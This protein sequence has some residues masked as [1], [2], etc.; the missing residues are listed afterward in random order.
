ML[1]EYVIVSI[2][3]FTLL[4]LLPKITNPS[5][6]VG[7]YIVGALLCGFSSLVLLYAGL[8]V[9]QLF[10]LPQ[11]LAL[12]AIHAVVPIFSV[13]GVRGA[14]RVTSTLSS[15]VLLLVAGF[16]MCSAQSIL[17]VVFAFEL[18]LFGALTLMRL[19]AKAERGVE[20]LTEM[21]IWSIVGSFSLIVGLLVSSTHTTSC[22]V[23]VG[24]LLLF[25]FA[26]K[27]PL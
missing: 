15:I 2:G 27:V 12:T 26:V 1:L 18:M 13:L 11:L 3:C 4:A 20:A 17:S 23:I 8:G 6:V 25:G 16:A 22:E 24:L 7:P 10:G 9:G 21:Y 19:T 5:T 14:S